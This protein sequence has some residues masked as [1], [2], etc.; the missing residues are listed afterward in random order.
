[1]CGIVAY[2]GNKDCHPILLDGLKRLEYR[3]YDSAG[4]ACLFDSKISI[5]KRAGKVKELQE[6]INTKKISK[7]FST[8]GISQL[9]K[10]VN[11]INFCSL[12]ENRLQFCVGRLEYKRLELTGKTDIEHQMYLESKFGVVDKT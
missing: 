1:M 8:I 7:D 12:S 9:K 10:Y 3:G 4:I 11:A 5:T 6:A 2:K